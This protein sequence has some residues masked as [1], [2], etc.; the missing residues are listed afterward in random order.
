MLNT[1]LEAV[2]SVLK[3]DLKIKN[4]RLHNGNFTNA[5]LQ[6]LVNSTPHLV[7]SPLKIRSSKHLD[8]NILKMDLETGVFLILNNYD[9]KEMLEILQK[10]KISIFNL[11]VKNAGLVSGIETQNLYS[12]GLDKKS[13]QIWALNFKTE[14]YLEDATLDN[15]DYG[16][17]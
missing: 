11:S 5:D 7:V 17:L 3:K 2:L 9:F 4:A 12:D 8:T 6:R 13:V 1:Y 14:I 10:A 16:I 15:L